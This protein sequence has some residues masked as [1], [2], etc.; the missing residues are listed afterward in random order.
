MLF[1]FYEIINYWKE[2]KTEIGRKC[3][4]MPRVTVLD[5]R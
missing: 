3:I 2:K 1:G 4:R 5:E